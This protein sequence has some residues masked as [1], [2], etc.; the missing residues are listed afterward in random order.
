MQFHIRCENDFFKWS[1]FFDSILVTEVMI[2]E[3]FLKY[4]Y[5]MKKLDMEVIFE[6]F[7]YIYIY[8]YI[9]LSWDIQKIWLW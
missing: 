1:F 2:L 9:Y 7:I 3:Y 6:T 5:I 4:D 8:I